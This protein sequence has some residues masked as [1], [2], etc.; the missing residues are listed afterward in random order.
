MLSVVAGTQG[1]ILHV[2]QARN[3]PDL[4]IHL[5]RVEVE[6]ETRGPEHIERITVALQDA[7]YRILFS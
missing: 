6:V 4:P 2:V 7:G 1:N 5:T 3:E